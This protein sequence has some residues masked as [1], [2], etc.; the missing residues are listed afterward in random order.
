MRIFERDWKEKKLEEI[1]LNHW[2]PLTLP[3]SPEGRGEG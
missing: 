3:L 2:I 1:N